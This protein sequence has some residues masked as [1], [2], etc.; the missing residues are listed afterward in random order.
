MAR[1]R[2]NATSRRYGAITDLCVRTTDPN[3]RRAYSVQLT[4]RAVFVRAERTA[5][6]VV[7]DFLAGCTPAEGDQLRDLLARFVAD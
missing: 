2:A 4:G 6:A 3:D 7:D 5:M 1:D